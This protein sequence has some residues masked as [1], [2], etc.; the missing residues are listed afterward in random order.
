MSP[1]GRFGEFVTLAGKPLVA[2]P[3]RFIDAGVLVR[4][5]PGALSKAVVFLVYLRSVDQRRHRMSARGDD[6]GFEPHGRKLEPPRLA[7]HRPF[8]VQAEQTI[9]TLLRSPA[10]LP[11][12]ESTI[13]NFGSLPSPRGPRP[14]ARSRPPVGPA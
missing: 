14:R 1:S 10:P 7:C 4:A 2:A 9:V 5:R 6:P 3:D 12:R 11:D 8:E 13:V